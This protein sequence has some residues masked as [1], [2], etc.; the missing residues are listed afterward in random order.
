MLA[1]RAAECIRETGTMSLTDELRFLVEYQIP[2][3]FAAS[4]DLE[5]GPAL[6]LA[7]S[8]Q[9]RNPIQ[10][11]AKA[12]ATPLHQQ[13]LPQLVNTKIKLSTSCSTTVAS[14]SKTH[15]LRLT[16]RKPSSCVKS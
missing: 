9:V 1:T 4:R 2:S 11:V 10:A 7:E 5:L 12:K 6:S 13:I 8:G 3:L 15:T 14:R 16:N